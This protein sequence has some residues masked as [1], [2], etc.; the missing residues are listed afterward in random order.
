MWNES[1]FRRTDL[2]EGYDGWQVHDATPQQLSEGISISSDDTHR[3][4]NL[5]KVS[6]SV[7]TT[8]T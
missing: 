5:V 8:P 1:Y 6:V 4:Y 7:V 2:P 3:I